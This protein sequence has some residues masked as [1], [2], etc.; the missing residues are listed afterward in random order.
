MKV[1]GRISLRRGRER[2][3]KNV[4]ATIW[5]NKLGSVYY[6]CG[7]TKKFLNRPDQK[8]RILFSI[9]EEEETCAPT[10]DEE[11]NLVLG[12]SVRGEDDEQ[13]PSS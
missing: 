6:F 7:R 8:K 1:V 13:F 11:N 10:N 5:K 3:D 9:P 2:T 4:Y 12:Q